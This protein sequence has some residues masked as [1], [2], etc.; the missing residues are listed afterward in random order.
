MAWVRKVDA[1][2]GRKVIA[3]NVALRHA[4][5]HWRNTISRVRQDDW[6]NCRI[7]KSRPENATLFRQS[8]KFLKYKENSVGLLSVNSQQLTK[9]LM[10]TVSRILPKLIP[11]Q[12]RRCSL[13]KKRQIKAFIIDGFCFWNLAMRVSILTWF[14]V[15]SLRSNLWALM[16]HLSARSLLNSSKTRSALNQLC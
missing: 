9:L 1:A 13:V 6:Q 11:S 15:R 4:F 2:I 5:T 14:V 8:V 7:F 16:R 3:F 10:F 12:C